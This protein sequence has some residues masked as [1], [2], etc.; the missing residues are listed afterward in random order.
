MKKKKQNK[1]KWKKR[2]KCQ[3]KRKMLL[4]LLVGVLLLPVFRIG[5]DAT[6][7]H[8]WAVVAI[9]IL[10]RHEHACRLLFVWRLCLSLLVADLH[11]E[12]RLA[13]FSADWL[14]VGPEVIQRYVSSACRYCSSALLI[15][16]GTLHEVLLPLAQTLFEALALETAGSSWCLI[17]VEVIK[18]VIRH[19]RAQRVAVESGTIRGVHELEMPPCIVQIDVCARVVVRCTSWGKFPHNQVLDFTDA[20]ADGLYDGVEVPNA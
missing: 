15:S 14:F 12:H 13:Y 9:P 16:E 4:L 10:F 11:A 2:K 19:L 5:D 20:V 3:M 6:R 17:L 7:A 8:W 1:G 18:P